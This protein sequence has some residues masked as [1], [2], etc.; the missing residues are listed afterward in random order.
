[1]PTYVIR[2]SYLPC[3]EVGQRS[4]QWTQQLFTKLRVGVVEWA[5]VTSL[6]DS[7]A[8]AAVGAS[9]APSLSPRIAGEFEEAKK[10]PTSNLLVSN[11]I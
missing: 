6:I 3:R 2:V 7:V 11:K 10:P 9:H 8:Y 1:M 4:E 5:C